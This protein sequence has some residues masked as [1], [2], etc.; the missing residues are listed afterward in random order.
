M[1]E[2]VGDTKV[3]E[4]GSR[5]KTTFIKYCGD[6]RPSDNV[7]PAQAQPGIDVEEK[8][9]N[10]VPTPHT[11][12]LASG[13]FD[14]EGNWYPEGGLQAWLVAFGSYASMFAGFG[15]MNTIGT[16]NAYIATHQVKETGVSKV[17]WIFSIYVFL[18]FFGGL[19]IG[20]AFD[21]YGPKYL[22]SAGGV[23]LVTGTMLLGVCTQYWHF[24]ICFSLLCGS[25]TTL[26]FT[27]A[28]AVLGHWFNKRRGLATGLA[29]TGGACGGVIFPLMLQSLFPKIGWAWATRLMG[30]IFLLMVTTGV[31][32]VRSRLPSRKGS[33]TT[34]RDVLPDFRIFLDGTGAMALSTAGLFFIE[35]GLFIPLTYLTSYA[36]RNGVEPTFA[37]Q[38]IAIFNGSSFFGRFIPGYAADKLGRFN[39]LIMTCA[40]CMISSFA[41]WL[42]AHGSI[43]LLVVLSVFLGFGTGSNISLTSIAVGQL[44]AT[45]EYGRY[46]STCYTIVSF[47]TLVG[48]PIAGALIK[49]A[50]GDYW[51]AIIFTG[52]CYV[53]ALICLGIVRVGKV[54]W[55]LKKVW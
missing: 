16:I 10:D 5:W 15:I 45:Q 8:A 18:A 34:W 50:D 26:I 32:L 13:S 38:L 20:P 31:F 2:D 54:G 47:G 12:Q 23:C 39:T 19:Q 40:M 14:E 1:T 17:S 27:P 4:L 11:D 51:A 49:A 22:I 25:G 3:A 53:L 44:C 46:Y 28:I 35:W 29:A 52:C 9:F 6:A 48:L 33:Q 43:P 37:Y 21:A 30:F 55:G 41:F 24:V 36:I 7:V 42:P